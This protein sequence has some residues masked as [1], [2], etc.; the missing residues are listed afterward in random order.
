MRVSQKKAQNGKKKSP[1]KVLSYAI[2]LLRSNEEIDRS[3]CCSST[4]SRDRDHDVDDH[5]GVGVS[6]VVRSP[7]YYTGRLQQWRAGYCFW[8]NNHTN[9]STRVVLSKPVHGLQRHTYYNAKYSNKNTEGFPYRSCCC[10]F[11]I[12][13]LYS[14]VQYKQQPDNVQKPNLKL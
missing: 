4:S 11:S 7:Y 12:I 9:S 14:R 10:R 2:T 5:V 8:K 6:A 3:L 13:S 1:C